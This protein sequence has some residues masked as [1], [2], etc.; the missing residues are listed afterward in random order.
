MQL[1]YAFVTTSNNEIGRWFLP[2][3]MLIILSWVLT[4]AS[5][6]TVDL[7]VYLFENLSPIL[8]GDQVGII[9]LVSQ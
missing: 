6:P 3:T 4:I 2:W 5:R 9:K 1:C 8:L 7:V